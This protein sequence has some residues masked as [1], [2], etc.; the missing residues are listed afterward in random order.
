MVHPS[1]DETAPTGPTGPSGSTSGVDGPIWAVLNGGSDFVSVQMATERLASSATG[2]CLSQRGFSSRTLAPRPRSVVELD[3]ATVLFGTRLADRTFR[4]AEGYGVTTDA[5]HQRPVESD[6]ESF[7]VLTAG[8]SQAQ[9]QAYNTAFD[10]CTKIAHAATFSTAFDQLS[11]DQGEIAARV[12]ADPRVVAARKSW[13]GCMSAAGYP[14]RNFDAPAETLLAQLYAAQEN[15]AG[16]G[17]FAQ[18]H[19]RE[20]TMA[21]TDWGCREKVY[22]AT[23]LQV[24]DELETAYLDAHEQLAAQVSSD[25]HNLLAGGTGNG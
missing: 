24:R 7:D 22:T 13:S 17:E 12:L 16:D 10:E 5:V 6:L 15:G 20:L 21:A 11:R 1:P 3:E 25:V 18:L 9:A 4:L 14:S 2:S 8:M 19:T 23:F